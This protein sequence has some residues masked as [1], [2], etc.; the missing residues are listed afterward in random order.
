[1][2]SITFAVLLRFEIA[3]LFISLQRFEARTR[4]NMCGTSF[5]GRKAAE[6]ATKSSEVFMPRAKC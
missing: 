1:M 5:L 3:F 2:K 4:V 6:L